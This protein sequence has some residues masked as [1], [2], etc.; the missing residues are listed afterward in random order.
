MP[1]DK[2]STAEWDSYYRRADRA[3][4]VA[5]DPFRRH[6]ERVAARERLFMA[7]AVL[8]LLAAV[9]AFVLLATQS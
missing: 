7:G 4:A 8:A 2:A 3:R 1:R 9:G 5:G 6:L